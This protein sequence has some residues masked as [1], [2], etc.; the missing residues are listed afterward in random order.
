MSFIFLIL[1]NIIYINLSTLSTVDCHAYI[2][3][4]PISMPIHNVVKN[5]IKMRGGNVIIQS[6]K[7][8]PIPTI[9]IQLPTLPI[10]NAKYSVAGGIANAVSHALV[11]P[12][13]KLT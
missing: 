7:T 9:P 12:I 5:K 11:L 2:N 4:P 8:L 10:F 3:T 6:L 1:F 13:G